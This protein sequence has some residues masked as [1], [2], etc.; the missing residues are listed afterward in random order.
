MIL[1]DKHMQCRVESKSAYAMA[2]SNLF[3][4]D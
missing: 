3:K 4:K 2:Y 1:M